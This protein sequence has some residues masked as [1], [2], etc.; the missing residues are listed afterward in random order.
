MLDYLRN[1]KIQQR[2]SFLKR[3]A[4]EVYSDPGNPEGY[5][6]T[7]ITDDMI[8]HVYLE[9]SERSREQESRRYLCTLTGGSS[10]EVSVTRYARAQLKSYLGVSLSMDHTFKVA[11]KAIVV[12]PEQKHVKVMKGGLFSVLNEESE[13][14]VWV[15]TCLGTI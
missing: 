7:P 4:L 15:S 2:A 13:I 10:S 11:N 1:L 8:T 14:L 9:F 3:P 12:T 5:A 6:N